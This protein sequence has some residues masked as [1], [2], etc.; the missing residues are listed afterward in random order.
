MKRI[1]FGLVVAGVA[2]GANAADVN[3]SRMIHTR[4]EPCCAR[5]AS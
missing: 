3:G 1:L 4:S 5:S 2:F